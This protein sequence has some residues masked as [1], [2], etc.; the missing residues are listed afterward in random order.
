MILLDS[1]SRSLTDYCLL[2]H[3][4]LCL[5]M[6]H[7]LD[8]TVSD[9][10]DEGESSL[11]IDCESKESDV[12]WKLLDSF[13]MWTLWVQIVI[14]LIVFWTCFTAVFLNISVLV[15]V[16][17]FALWCFFFF[18]WSMIACWVFLVGEDERSLIETFCSC[19]CRISWVIATLAWNTASWLV[20]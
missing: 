12:D 19:C 1:R 20:N 2:R 16:L 3:T 11:K 9:N 10:S 4:V 5:K 15:R 6:I 17:A 13:K 18:F 7:E 14:L 8:N